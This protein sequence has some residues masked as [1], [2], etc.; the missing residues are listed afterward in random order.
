M[1]DYSTEKPVAFDGI[2]LL[3]ATENLEEDAFSRLAS[4]E[5][6]EVTFDI[7]QYHDLSSGGAFQ[8]SSEGAFSFAEEDS[9]E[10]VGS[11]PFTANTIEAEVDGEAASAVHT[12][13]TL[14][15]RTRVQSD[16]SGTRLSQTRSALSGCASWASQAQSVAESGSAAKMT[17]YFKS[18]S[19]ST[20]STVA[21]VF[22]RIRSE[23]SSTSGGASTWSC[24]DFY[25]ACGG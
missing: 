13:F 19:S 7:A 22:S 5:S 24:T 17:E 25:G 3:I 18:S 6:L 21:G 12:A 8:I 2:K 15:R 20:R 16:C 9:T 10:L 14:E 11:V 4:G 1:A 23:C